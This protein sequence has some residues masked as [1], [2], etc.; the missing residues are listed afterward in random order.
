MQ[1]SDVHP[2][3]FCLSTAQFSVIANSGSVRPSV[4]LSITLVIHA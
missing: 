3:V 2:T 4:R 1:M